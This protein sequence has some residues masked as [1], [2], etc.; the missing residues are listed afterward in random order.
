MLVR[1]ARVCVPFLIV[2]SALSAQEAS[3]TQTA[4][5]PAKETCSIAGVVVK[6]GTNEPL[7]KAHVLLSKW[8]N[9]RS[10]YSTQTDGSGHFAILKIEPGR[11]RLQVQRTGYLSQFY[12]EDPSARRGAV[13]ALSSGNDIPDLLFHMVPPAIISGRITDED[14][15]PIPHVVIEA[16]RRN[17]WEGRRQ[18][19]I[20]GQ[21]QTN[22][23]G[24]FRLSELA[25]GR[26][27]LRAKFHDWRLAPKEAVDQGSA[28]QTGYAPVYFPGTTDEARAIPIDLAQGEEMSSV[29]F[30][31]I[32][33][34]T[35]HVRGHVFDAVTGEPAKECSLTLVHHDP[36]ASNLADYAEGNTSCEKGVFQFSDVPPG[37][38]IVYAVVNDSGKQRLAHTP[39]NLINTSSDDVT[40]T[41]GQGIELAGRVLVEGRASLDLSQIHFWLRDR[42]QYFHYGGHAALRA[43]GTLTIENIPEGNYYIDAGGPSTGAAP[44]TYLKSA[45]ANGQEVLEKGL[46]VGAGGDQGPLEIVLDTGGTSIEGSVTDENGLPSLGAIV[47]LVPDVDRRTQFRLYMD[48]TTDHHGQFVLRGVTPGAYKLFSWKEIEDHGWENP[49]FLAPFESQGTRVIAEENGHIAV[50]LKLVPTEKPK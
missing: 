46:K 24:E 37:T 47:A 43:D 31:L 9:P 21:A 40:L 17:T 4:K 50:R 20:Y 41:V 1:F 36:N 28:S 45:R 38:Y 49:E 39:I 19:Q 3:S 42:E 29:N 5:V 8:D 34:R 27:L 12:G 23:L 48:A 14:G 11:Y 16:M 35:L 44:D 18:L 30:T 10:G 6:L 26:Y 22:D 33:L 15:E 7:S 25:K 2:S 32:P 13:L